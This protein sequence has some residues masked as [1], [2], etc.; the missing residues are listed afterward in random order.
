MP[1]LFACMGGFTSERT[2]VINIGLEGM[3]L[4]AACLCALGS[5]AWGPVPGV[6]VGLVGGVA[7]SLLH[8]LATQVYKIDHVVSGMAIN[9][10][11]AGGTHFLYE[12][13]SNP[14][15]T[16]VPVLPIE[17]YIVLALLLP[18]GLWW[19]M[20]RTRGG[21]RMLAVSSDPDKARLM[22]VQ[23]IRVRLFGLLAT[24]LLTGL[25]GIG[26]VTYP[27]VFTNNMT[28]GNGYIALAALV[29]G[30]WRPIPAMLACLGFGFFTAA[31]LVLPGVKAIP[32]LP[33]ELWSS[34]PYVVTIIA[35]AGLL[36]K[37]RTPAGL[38][39]E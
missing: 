39:K 36:G 34:L 24:G 15:K 21:L 2:G 37:S 32:T 25:G 29:L 6:L 14:D 9:A 18:I 4:T 20:A 7:M 5:A 22:G 33:P 27:K 30:G 11:A 13:F 19:Y 8:W 28:A 1:L 31:R 12:R 3:M 16:T 35:L 17:I 26:F 10:M 23:P 38:G